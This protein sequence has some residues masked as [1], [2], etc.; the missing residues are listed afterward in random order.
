MFAAFG[1]VPGG[2]RSFRY[3]FFCHRDGHILSRGKQRWLKGAWLWQGS[4]TPS[5]S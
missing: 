2:R 5:N 1:L 3:W 4:K